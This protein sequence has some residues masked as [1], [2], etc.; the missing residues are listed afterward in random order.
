MSS[1]RFYYSDFWLLKLSGSINQWHLEKQ[2]KVVNEFIAVIIKDANIVHSCI[3]IAAHGCHQ[4]W[5][6][7]GILDDGNQTLMF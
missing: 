6:V 1:G 7:Y 3:L 2:H 4:A 5:L